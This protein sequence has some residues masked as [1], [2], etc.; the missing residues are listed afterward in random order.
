MHK[1]TACYP[2]PS[3]GCLHL[4]GPDRAAFIQ[5]QTTNDVRLLTPTRAVTTVLTS[6]AARVLDVLQLLAEGETMHI[7]PLPGRA[8]T[9]HAF[10]RRRIFFNDDVTLTD[11]S[12]EYFQIDVEGS[13][14]ADLLR[15]CKIAEPPALNGVVTGSLEA[16]RVRIFGQPGLHGLGYRVL[17]AASDQAALT[18]TLAQAGCP[19]LTAAE[20]DL[21]RIEAG[22]PGPARELTEAHTPLEINL[23]V[24]ISTDKGCYTGQEIIARQINYDKITRSMV[25]LRLEAPIHAGARVSAGGKSAGTVTSA[26]E[27]PRYGPIAL[28]VLKRPNNLAG[29]KVVVVDNEV[30]IR[31]E[32]IELPFR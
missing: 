13:G 27:S 7:L 26:V 4:T 22:L 14:A 12:A 21:L 23:Q 29:T 30:N 18:H 6:S 28:A 9:T 16:A 3:A 15:T 25:G 8:A 2:R 10:L 19:T 24:A 31:G 17:A 5:R 11:A 20:Y 32:V 1:N